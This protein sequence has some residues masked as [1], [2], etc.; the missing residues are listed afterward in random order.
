[1]AQMVATGKIT[2]P[3]SDQ[4]DMSHIGRFTSSSSASRN[5]VLSDEEEEDVLPPAKVLERQLKV[6]LQ[7]YAEAA[8]IAYIRTQ[9]R[10]TEQSTYTEASEQSDKGEA[11]IEG[12]SAREGDGHSF[13]S[14]SSASVVL[15]PDAF[16]SMKGLSTINRHSR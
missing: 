6:A 5:S 3:S 7:T 13:S 10:L 9:R 4:N 16:G 8:R 15:C 2:E 1:M 12:E 14:V 11:D